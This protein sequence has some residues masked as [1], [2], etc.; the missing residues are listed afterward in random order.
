[1]IDRRGNLLREG[2][3]YTFR[4][5]ELIPVPEPVEI[6]ADTLLDHYTALALEPSAADSIV[7]NHLTGQISRLL[8][9]FWKRE[10]S[11]EGLAGTRYTARLL[12]WPPDK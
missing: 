10:K 1:M 9:R 5:G 8:P 12:V 2:A 3:Y 7:N 6:C 4:R 11:G